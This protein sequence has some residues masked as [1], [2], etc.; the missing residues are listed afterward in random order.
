MIQSADQGNEN[1]R[2]VRNGKTGNKKTETRKAET[3]KAKNGKSDIRRA[4]RYCVAIMV[5]ILLVLSALWLPK[6]F[7]DVS[8]A[9]MYGKVTLTEQEEPDVLALTTGYEESL[10]RRLS[11]FAE[12][13]AGQRQYYV[14]KQPKEL[15]EEIRTLLFESEFRYNTYGVLGD[16]IIGLFSDSMGFSREEFEQRMRIGQTALELY[17]W[18]Q[19]VIYSDDYAQ[20][21]NFVLWCFCLKNAIG[22]DLTILMDARDHTV[23]AVQMTGGMDLQSLGKEKEYGINS[24]SLYAKYELW[25]ILN[26]YYEIFPIHAVEDFERLY[27][28]TLE[29][30]DNWSIT[31]AEMDGVLYDT[32]GKEVEINLKPGSPVLRNADGE[33]WYEE[34]GD[35]GWDY[36]LPLGGNKIT[37]GTYG[38]EK[39]YYAAPKDTVYVMGIREIYELIPEFQQFG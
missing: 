35:G 39:S 9:L 23:Y 11:G 29:I 25:G 18:K 1:R 27:S 34:N 4:A 36:S 28:S 38:F 6:M 26:I 13:L 16:F 21:V 30:Y 12:G 37:F 14:D 33:R 15:T 31:A 24:F 2:K 7:F 32:A 10:Y 20:G 3:G 19:Y 8:D 17:Q 22:D 5:F